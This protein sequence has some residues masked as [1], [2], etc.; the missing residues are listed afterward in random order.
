[1][2]IKQWQWRQKMDPRYVLCLLLLYMLHAFFA[3]PV[4]VIVG[5]TWDRQFNF[6]ADGWG[7]YFAFSVLLAV[8]CFFPI[9][10]PL[11]RG[12]QKFHPPSP[13]M[14]PLC[15]QVSMVACGSNI[16]ATRTCKLGFKAFSSAAMSLLLSIALVVWSVEQPRSCKQ[17]QRRGGEK[18]KHTLQDRGCL[19]A[20]AS[21]MAT[22]YDHN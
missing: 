19:A 18:A 12:R 1:M 13:P 9:P 17:Q 8:A 4:P 21:K 15:I 20:A 3:F 7:L 6:W 16:N 10:G 2:N 22:S 14:S 5:S 11:P